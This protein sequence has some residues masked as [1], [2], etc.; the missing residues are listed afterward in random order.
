[1]NLSPEEKINQELTNLSE[2]DKAGIDQYQ[3]LKDARFIRIKA[4]KKKSLKTEFKYFF[5]D[6]KT[7]RRWL[8]VVFIW[9]VVAFIFLI[10]SKR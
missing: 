7:N 8:V 6:E 4:A 1:M 10:G 3:T 9:V 5:D 2:S